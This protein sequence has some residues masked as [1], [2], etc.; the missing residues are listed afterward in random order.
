M[1]SGNLFTDR[2]GFNCSA[3]QHPGRRKLSGM[4]SANK[5]ARANE[6]QME[7]RSFTCNYLINRL[8]M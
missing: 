2:G 3:Y 7:R 1:V 8:Q 4:C 6:K 5:V